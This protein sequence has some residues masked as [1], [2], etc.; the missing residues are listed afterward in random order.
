MNTPLQNNEGIDFENGLEAV[1][2]AGGLG[3]RLRNTVPDLPK[4][5]APVAG[6]PFLFYVI[7]YLRSQGVTRFI[8]S[9]GYKAE[10]ITKYLGEEFPTLSY[11][12]VIEEEPLGTGGAIL[13]A[14][15]K[16]TQKDIVV[17]NGDTLCK[18]AISR[19]MQQHIKTG[20]DCTLLLKPMER[21]DRYG[22]VETDQQARVT[23][24]REK[25]YYEQ[26]N[27]NG[28]LYLLNVPA[29]LSHSFPSK[30]SFESDYLEK[31]TEHDKIFAYTDTGYFVDIGIPQDH[32]KA[33]LDL[34]RPIPGVQE[35]SK[36]WTLF[37]DRDGVI[38]HEKTDG[39]ILNAG[40][41]RFYEN[42]LP[43]L[44]R[45]SGIFGKIII[46]SN[47]RGVGKGLM[48]E[49]DLAG[50]HDLLVNQVKKHGGRIDAIYYCTSTDHL[51][52]RRKPNPGMAFEAMRDHA[53]IVASRSLMLGNKLSDM[54]F[55]R[56]AGLYSVFLATT[57]PEI[58]FPHPDIDFRFNSL[59][60]FAN[61]L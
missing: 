13:L 39:Y 8:F 7:N 33:N 46:I 20:A 56:N 59:P 24:F 27:I 30:F 29:F 23:R 37:I 49:E 18:A 42:V 60:D 58:P 34:M 43:A 22:A 28:G 38:N 52:N 55:A 26:G 11:E 45:L 25:Q 35:F 40:E 17:A 1:V 21:F 14:C 9:L 6:R 10:Q 47:Q 15:S 19:A 54:R 44:A 12:V 31:A 32:E 16:T 4:C 50:I 41:F 36:D 2:L 57:N 61:S 3:T 51:N 5:M 48:T 53:S